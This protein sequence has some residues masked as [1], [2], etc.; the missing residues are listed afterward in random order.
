MPVELVFRCPL[1][2]IVWR[3][4]VV[5]GM[6]HLQR[7]YGWCSCGNVLRR[8]LGFGRRGDGCGYGLVRGLL[9]SGWPWPSTVAAEAPKGPGVGGFLG[10]F[11]RCGPPDLR[12]GVAE[13]VAFAGGISVK[14]VR[15]L[16]LWAIP[17]LRSPSQGSDQP[18]DLYFVVIVRWPRGRV[19]AAG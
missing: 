10:G 2:R 4:A 13:G 3:D 7:V 1:R 15:L 17:E 8:N 11:G 9:R 14:R 6:R 5:V 18:P 16:G 12:G 19:W